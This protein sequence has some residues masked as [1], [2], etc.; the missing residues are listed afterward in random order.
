MP[1][2]STPMH[3]RISACCLFP[4]IWPVDS[5]QATWTTRT[6][7]LVVQLAPWASGE[8]TI[9]VD[10]MFFIS[11]SFW[12]WQE[13]RIDSLAWGATALVQIYPSEKTH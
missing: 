3:T 1:Q 11:Q 2:L 4:F 7:P 6:D 5:L 12:P 10:L 8:S 9:K 13:E